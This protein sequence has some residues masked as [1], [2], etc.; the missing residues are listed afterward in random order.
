MVVGANGPDVS[1]QFPSDA[2][3]V[4]SVC[5]MLWADQLPAWFESTII[6][7]CAKQVRK[8]FL[9]KN[10]QLANIVYCECLTI[11]NT[12]QK[13]KADKQN[14]GKHFPLYLPIY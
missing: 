11:K 4:P 5:L 6:C 8:Y 1:V 9:R 12:L 14:L 7:C 2:S 10:L 3:L 13:T